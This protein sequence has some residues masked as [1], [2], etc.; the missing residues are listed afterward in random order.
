M[1]GIRTGAV[2]YVWLLIYIPASVRVIFPIQTAFFSV[3]VSFFSVNV[4]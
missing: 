1:K 2:R 3:N 4:W